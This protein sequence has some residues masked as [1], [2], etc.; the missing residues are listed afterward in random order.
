MSSRFYLAAAFAFAGIFSFG[1]HAA[2]C[3]TESTQLNEYQS[4]QHFCVGSKLLRAEYKTQTQIIVDLV[5]ITQIEY[6]PGFEFGPIQPHR[7]TKVHYQ[8]KSGATGVETWEG[9]SGPSGSG[10]DTFAYPQFDLFMFPS[11][12]AYINGTQHACVGN[13]VNWT[14]KDDCEIGADGYSHCKA[15]SAT[16][17]GESN[18]DRILALVKGDNGQSYYK[19]FDHATQ[20]RQTDN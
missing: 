8:K 10:G 16:L 9:F 17:V 19:E 15:V 5:T 13:K 12:C 7:I 14:D 18:D 20:T 2:D 1:A 3:S 4:P 6:T 11:G